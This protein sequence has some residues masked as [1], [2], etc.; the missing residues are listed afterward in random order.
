MGKEAYDDYQRHLRDRE[1]NSL[2]YRVLDRN[3]RFDSVND[4][5]AYFD[6]AL[7]RSISAAKIKAGDL[8]LLE[9]NMRVP[10]DMVLLRTSENGV[11][12]EQRTAEPNHPTLPTNK[13]EIGNT[14]I[15]EHV[16]VTNSPTGLGSRPASGEE[17]E[18]G[19]CFVRTD[20][21][22]GET[23]WKLKVAVTKTQNCSNR[24]LLRM[25]GELYGQFQR[26]ILLLKLF[27]TFRSYCFQ[28]MHRSRISILS[29][30]I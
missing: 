3:S 4:V 12:A 19:S 14:D 24:E 23:D 13:N 11:A 9:K 5:E 29:L 28:L 26:G 18:G 8:V 1:A 21:L 27:L 15:N 17:E 6:A 22:D 25:K 16:P 2:K 7:T 20:Q 30:G 10:A